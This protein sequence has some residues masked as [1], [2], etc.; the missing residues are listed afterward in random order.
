MNETIPPPLPPLE[1]T[2]VTTHS[3]SSTPGS[4]PAEQM[5]IRGVI[6][7]VEAVLREPRRVMFA[8]RQPGAGAAVAALIGIAVVSI[9]IYGLVV[10]SFSGGAQWWGAPLKIAVGLLVSALICLPSLFIFA[11]L[12]GAATR[13]GEVIGILAGMLALTTILLIGF[14]PVAWV[15]SQSTGSLAWMGT[16]HLA[17]WGVSALFGLRFLH[18]AFAHQ[19][20]SRAG[21]KVWTL[22]YLLVS[23][24]M[25]AALR[26]LLGPASTFL[27]TEKRFFLV[28][29]LDVVDKPAP[30]K[31]Q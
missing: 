30:V 10:G 20:R 12:G 11:T 15:F 5:P 16:L 8:L 23:L 17:F 24:Q 29:W 19:V 13:F 1:A 2:P 25:T 28:H 9:A 4:D 14:A 21:I 3:D 6:G 26:P 7:A 27:P 31:S 22:L 18:H